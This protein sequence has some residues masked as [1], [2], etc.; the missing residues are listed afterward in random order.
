MSRSWVDTLPHLFAKHGLEV[1]FEK[2]YESPDH[3]MPIAAQASYLGQIER[4]DPG[5]EHYVDQYREEYKS[6]A[7]VDVAFTC[8]VG[9][10]TLPQ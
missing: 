10:K 4:G 6:G 5:G 8:V 9:Q 2:R 3:Y 7:T 1:V